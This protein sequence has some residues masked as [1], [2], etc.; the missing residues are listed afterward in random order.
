MRQIFDIS[1]DAV[2]PEEISIRRALG[3]GLD[4]EPS[5]KTASLIDEAFE[6]FVGLAK[7]KGLFETI[8]IEEF[9]PLYAGAGLNESKTPLQGIYPS[10]EHMALFALTLGQ[11]VSRRIDELFRANDFALGYV[12]DA[13]ASE[14]AELAA[15][16]VEDRFDNLVVSAEEPSGDRSQLRYSPGYCGWHISGQGR[17]FERLR[18]GDIGIALNSSYLMQPLKSVSGVIV[19]GRKEIHFF[20]NSFPFCNDCVTKTCR[21][22][23]KHIM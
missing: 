5:E 17:L 14:G 6:D 15:E 4:N 13:V 10:A 8:S 1:I 7:P 11:P 20:N 18:P 9:T 21:D 3:L 2:I 12:L 23:L 22:R 16:A 19:S